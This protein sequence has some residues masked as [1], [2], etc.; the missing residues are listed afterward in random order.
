[1][2]DFTPE[3][4]GAKTQRLRRVFHWTLDITSPTQALHSTLISN[5]YLTT[6]RG[7]F[8]PEYPVNSTPALPINIAALI[9]TGIRFLSSENQAVTEFSPS[10]TLFFG[11]TGLNTRVLILPALT[12]I[13]SLPA[14]T[15]L[16]L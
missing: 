8:S 10:K 14:Y 12:L 3:I 1:M 9:F 16:K 13:D 15:I 5:D 2:C 4:L 11:M 6:L 7:F